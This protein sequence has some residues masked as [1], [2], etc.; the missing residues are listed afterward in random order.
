MV[1]TIDALTPIPGLDIVGRGIYLRPQQP[2]EL[3]QLLFAHSAYKPYYSRETAST[4]LVPENYEVNDSPP[5]PSDQALNQVVIEES[6][7]R[8]E[9]QTSLDISAATSN[10][11]FSIDV[12]ASQTGQVRSQEDAYYALRNSFIPLW[13]VYLPNTSAFSESL[14]DIPVP[15]PYAPDHR[16]AYEKFFERFGTHYVKRVWVGGKAM[17]AFTVAKSSE[18]SKEDIRAGIK[19]SLTGVASAGRNTASQTSKEK[20]QSNSECMVFGKGG[21]ELKLASLSTLDE[22]QYNNWLATI[23]DNPQVIEFEVAGIWNL[24]SDPAKAAALREAYAEATVFTPL[25]VVFNLDRRIHVFRGETHFSYDMDKGE[26]TRPR[27][28]REQWP[29]LA[30][31]GFEQVDAAFLGK[32]LTSP[33]N[34]DLSRKLFFFNREKYLRLD[35]DTRTVDPG[36]PKSIAAGWPGVTFDRIDAAL[37]TGPGGLYFFR[38]NQYIRFNT[39]LN[40]VDDDYPEMVSRRWIGVNFDRIDAAVYWGNAKAYFFRGNQHIRYDMVTYC[41]DPGYPKYIIGNYVEDWKFF[42]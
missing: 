20:L 3:K 38:G 30:E 40:R 2:F 26:T 9:K 7:E 18:L 42:D 13:S 8:F 4:Y 36:Y 25:R 24:V 10:A 33:E 1:D 29:M 16:W 31:Y 19:A 34:E 15:V 37:N 5:M 17:L 6:W 23:K 32:Y 21:D 39:L 28:L 12:N 35:V 22:I 27:R 14:F 11:S 41:A